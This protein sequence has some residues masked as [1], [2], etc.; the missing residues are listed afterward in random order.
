MDCTLCGS[1]I[2]DKDELHKHL[3]HHVYDR[4]YGVKA[5]GL[6]AKLADLELRVD[7]LEQLIKVLE[8]VHSAPTPKP[9]RPQQ[10]AH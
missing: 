6:V 9:G 1:K 7:K 3:Q 5:D 8:V 2:E 10:G 4:Q